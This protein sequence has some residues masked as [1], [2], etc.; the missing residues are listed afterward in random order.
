MRQS[1]RNAALSAGLICLLFAG[2]Q[3]RA[4][5]YPNH[6]LKIIQG[7]AP[8]GTADAISRIVGKEL[9]EQMKQPIVVEARPGAGGNL[10]ADVVSKSAPDGY[11]LVLLTTAH[12]ISPAIY[13]SLPFDPIK[14]FEFIG[15]IA[16]VP[17]VIVVNA[18]SPYKTL[19]EL[20]DAARAKPGTITIGNA[21]VGTGQ[22]LCAELFAEAVKAKFVNV[23]FRGDTAAAAGLLSHTVNV[24]VAPGT[25]IRGNIVA[26]KFRALGISSLKRWKDLP[27]V[28]TIA[29]TGVAPNFNVVG[30]LALGTAHGVPKPI[31]AKLSREL[32]VALAKPEADQRI[33]AFGLITNYSTS[34]EF[35][36]KVESE[37]ARWKDIAEKANI[38]KR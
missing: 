30:F 32:K 21:G 22:H 31:V 8:G 15:N 9:S 23:P 35:K 2:S 33:G 13:K 12:V 28:A 4:E 7:Y 38:P 37:I 18:D 5:D 19:K 34:A 11:T 36:T 27:D 29:E 14:D 1:V 6:P 25:A 16:D 24:V 20:A 26:G 17:Y 3:A 10:A